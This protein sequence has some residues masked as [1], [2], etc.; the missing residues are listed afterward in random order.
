MQDLLTR[1]TWADAEIRADVR[2]FV[3]EHLGDV[4]VVLV[5][6]ESGDLKK[7]QHTVGVQRQYPGTAGKIESRQLAVHRVYATEAGHATLDTA[8]ACRS[9]GATTL[10]AASRPVSL[11]RCDRDETAAGDP[12]DRRRRHRQAALRWATGDEAYGSDP[13][14]A[15]RLRQ[16]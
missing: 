2:A 12:H 6:D 16:L 15:A 10:I 1:V 4:E 5:I 14:L 13:R 8:L 9:H 3:G 7:G 11:S